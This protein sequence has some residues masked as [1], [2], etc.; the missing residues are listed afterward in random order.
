MP[1]WI[2]SLLRED[3]PVPIVDAASATTTSWPLLAASRAT[4]SPTTPA[5]TTRTCMTSS[6]AV[7]RMD[8]VADRNRSGADD[9]AVHTAIGVPEN[10][11]QRL[12]N[13]KIANSGPRL[14]V[15]CRAAHDALDDFQ[16]R[17]IAHRDV[18]IEQLELMPG[19]PA[20][21]VKIGAKS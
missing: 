6:S 14:N 13:R 15:R 21:D 12:R 5:P 9:F 7:R 1:A 8:G 19:R 2:T 10:P 17:V 20:I 4:A 3:V 18:A 16:S 11:Q